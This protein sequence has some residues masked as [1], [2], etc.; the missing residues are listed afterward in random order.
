MKHRFLLTVGALSVAATVLAGSAAG[1]PPE[2]TTERVV[3][4]QIV[5]GETVLTITAGKV[6][7]R[8]HVHRVGRKLYRVIFRAVPKR[9]RLTDGETTYRAVGSVGGNFLARNPENENSIVAGFFRARVN[10]VGPGGL[11]GSIRFSER[12]H[13]NGETTTRDRGTCAFVE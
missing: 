2:R 4:E 7:T 3:G 12:L 1:N 6:V 9:V 8:E 5:C 13:R 11:F 10:I